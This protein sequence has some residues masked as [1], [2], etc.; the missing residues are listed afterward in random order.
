M[1]GFRV[2]GFRV[3]RI[4]KGLNIGLKSLEAL[5]VLKSSRVEGT[6]SIEQLYKGLGF[7]CWVQ[8]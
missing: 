6:G 4:H 8:G 5:M 1:R 2:Q 3:Y 7:G